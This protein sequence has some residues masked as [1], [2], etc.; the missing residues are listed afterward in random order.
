[1]ALPDQFLDELRARTPMMPLVARRVKLAR[2]GKSWKGCC[3]FHNEKTPSFYVYDDGYHCFGCAAHGDCFTFVMQTQGS[4]F[5]EAVKQLAGEAGMEVP[6]ASP[7]QAAAQA[8]FDTLREVLERAAAEFR[9]LL[10]A[11]EGRAALDYLLGRGL[12]RETIARFGLGWSGP[13]RGSLVSLLRA[14]GASDALIAETGLVQES[15][16]ELFFNRVMFPIRDRMGRIISFGGR[17][18][19]DGVPKYVNGPETKLFHKRRHLYGLD[20][21]KAAARQGQPMLLVEGYMDVIALHQAGFT[22]AVAPLGTALTDEQLEEMWDISPM[23]TLCFDGDKAGARAALRAVML[24]LPKLTPEKSL[25]LVTLSGGEDPDTL[26]RKQGADAFGAVLEGARPI[27]ACLYELLAEGSL[28]TTPEARAAF[29]DRLVEAAGTIAH[30]GLASEIRRSLLD[31]FFTEGRGPARAPGQPA[32]RGRPGA[33]KPVRLPARPVPNRAAGI[34]E[35]ARILTAIPLC[36]PAVL[37]DLE[38]AWGRIALEPDMARLR[39]ATLAWCDTA[40]KLDSGALITH[41]HQ[42]GLA[43]VVARVLSSTPRPLP[44]CTYPDAQPGEVKAAWHHLFQVMHRAQLEA[45]IEAA[46]ADVA[47][48]VDGLAQERLLRLRAAHEAIWREPGE[49]AEA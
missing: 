23:P 6:E 20:V 41:L 46:R 31:R 42:L 11:P 49:E 47:A 2:S 3:P 7:S 5:I 29:R 39:D 9:R 8:L 18:L 40:P 30:K 38:E 25:K 48:G 24:A 32:L 19:G 27:S 16:R 13:G 28:L 44:A 4:S 17:L 37:P 21:A 34:A 36:H 35:C 22:G 1:M 33:P 10:D 26:I 43:D 12:T 45:D 15:G 14:E